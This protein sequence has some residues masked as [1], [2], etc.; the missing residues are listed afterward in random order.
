VVPRNLGIEYS[1]LKRHPYT[2]TQE[3][4]Y[5]KYISDTNASPEQE[6]MENGTT[7]WDDFF[8]KSHACIRASMLPK[9]YGRGV[10]FDEKGKV[11]LYSIDSQE[12]Q[13]LPKLGDEGLK[14]I[15]AMRSSRYH[16]N[17]LLSLKEVGNQNDN[18]YRSPKRN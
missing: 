18:L 8:S 14:V 15:P 16:K 10:H 4:C 6:L 17:R 9:K 2:Y 5:L 11:A 1:L 7:I 13:K 12:Y 3:N